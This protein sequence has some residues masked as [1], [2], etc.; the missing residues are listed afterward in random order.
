MSEHKP[1]L[2]VKKHLLELNPPSH[3]GLIKK[4]AQEHSIPE[5]EILDAS[6]SL[7]PYGTPF[8]HA[9]TGMDLQDLLNKGLEKMEQY[10]DNRY[11]DF[12]E[13]A[14]RFV[15]MGVTADNIIPGNGSTEIIRLVAE[16]TIN[17]GDTVLIPQPT[18]SEYEVQCEVLGANIKYVLQEDIFEL[19]NELLDEAKI[20]FV[21]TPNNPTGRLLSR[22]QIIGLAEKCALHKTILFVDEAFIELADPSQS[23]ADMVEG[24]EYL[25]IQRSLT[26]SFAIPGIRMGFGIANSSLAKVLNN[27]RLSWNLGCIA[28]TVA[29]ALLN[30]DGGVNSRYLVESRKFIE[31]ERY[32]L[33]EKLSRRGF[34]PIES[35]VNYIFV[36]ITDLSLNSTELSERMALHAVLIRDCNS[37]QEI[38]DNFIRIAIRTRAENE[39]V[40]ATIKQVIYEWGREQAEIY[41]DTNL[42]N[43]AKCGRMGSNLECDYYCCHFEDQ[44]CT[45]CFCPFY[46]CEDERTGGQWI[47]SSSGGHVWSCLYCN[48]IH[49]PE[50]VDGLIAIFTKEG[51]GKESLEKAWKNV[52]ETHL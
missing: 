23:T 47:D 33:M 25:F 27:A 37:F 21:C 50:V 26:K 32:F 8:D 34:K 51:R 16:C 19:D 12:R 52:M 18:F 10:P 44:D 15:K 28:D 45:F 29:T 6:A 13:A 46:P 38:G 22:E 43:A 5:D 31:T 11:N 35:S 2:P 4:N 9:Y 20:L 7:N 48:V 1:S 3:G 36:D 24:N 49:K 39:K 17:D 41:L 42:E 40:V 14:A 30:M